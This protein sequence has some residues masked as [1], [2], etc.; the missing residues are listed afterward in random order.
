M[1][2]PVYVTKLVITTTSE[3]L[4]KIEAKWDRVLIIQVFRISSLIN[5]VA[6]I[7]RL[8]NTQKSALHYGLW[9]KIISGAF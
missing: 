7:V 2:D 4:K 1:N 5:Y 8:Q 6:L 9:R 3:K